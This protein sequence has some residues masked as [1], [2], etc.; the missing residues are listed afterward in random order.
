MYNINLIL[1]KWLFILC[2]LE[3]CFK[4]L[5]H[6][7]LATVTSYF[8]LFVYCRNFCVIFWLCWYL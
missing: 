2:K 3:I 5:K 6:M 1:S 7:Q 4:I 8:S